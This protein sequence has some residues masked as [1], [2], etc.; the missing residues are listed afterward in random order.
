MSQCKATA[1]RTGR[2]CERH[3]L[4]GGTV[5]LSHGG[6]A[7][8]V[9]RVAQQR[10]ALAR[11]AELLGPDVHADPAEVLIA[12]VK[13]SA[14]MLGAAQEAVRAEEADALHALGEA[15]MLAGRLSKLALDSGIEQRL[16]RQ[17]EEAGALVGALITRAVNGLELDAAT[18]ARAFRV[19]RRE[20]E[21]E[22]VS[23]GQYG[24]LS[25]ADLDVEIGR[26]VHQLDEHDRADALTNFPRRLAGAVDA[27]LGALDLSDADQEKAAAAAAYLARDAAEREERARHRHERAGLTRSSAAW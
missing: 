22:R 26:V 14:A 18:A 13:A 21:L 4:K 20:V 23:L 27:A 25:I 10:T 19:I 16:A 6:A 11:A 15:A 12:A 17:A 1:N 24:N 8:Q 2:R 5:C 3:A 7:K 9:R